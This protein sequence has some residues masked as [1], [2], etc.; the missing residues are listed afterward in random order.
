MLKIKIAAAAQ[1]GKANK[2]LI[3]FLARQIGVKRNDV[4][5]ISGQTKA[6]KTIKVSGVTTLVFLNR[7]GLSK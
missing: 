2:S 4:A 3:D 5:I 6:T 7:L 1:R